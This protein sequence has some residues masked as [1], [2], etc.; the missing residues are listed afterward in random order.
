MSYASYADLVNQLPEEKLIEYADD[1]GDGVAD[2]GRIE[3]ALNKA[4]EEIDFYLQ[5]RYPVPLEPCPKGVRN[6]AVNIAIYHL[7]SRRGFRDNTSDAV[8]VR[9]YEGSLSAGENRRGKTRSAD[10]R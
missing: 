7:A 3:A 2:E 5:K 8:I 10:G 9:R 1:N 6:L 4:D